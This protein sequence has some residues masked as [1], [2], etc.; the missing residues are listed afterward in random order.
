MIWQT[1]DFKKLA[2]YA[3]APMFR[4]IRRV[5]ILWSILAPLEIISREI[6]YK[7]QHNSQVVYLEKMLNEYF[8]VP[9]YDNQL[10]E[11]TKTVYIGD[12][13]QAPKYYFYQPAD[14]QPLYMGL[15]YVGGGTGPNNYKFIVNVPVGYAFV[16]E[17]LRAEINYYKLAGKKYIIQTY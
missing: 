13:P 1:V 14:N 17:K 4:K 6:L 8:S 2:F 5:S 12:V 11:S 16:E 15:L 7:M 3:L 10:H 9:G